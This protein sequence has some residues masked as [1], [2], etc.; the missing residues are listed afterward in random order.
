MMA[1]RT[2]TDSTAGGGSLFSAACWPRC[3]LRAATR[4][5]THPEPMGTSS[6]A[7]ERYLIGRRADEGPEPVVIPTAVGRPALGP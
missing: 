6:R 7:P 1:G 2:A 3:V 5:A 4:P